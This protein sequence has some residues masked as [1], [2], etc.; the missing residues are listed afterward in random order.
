LSLQYT[1]DGPAPNYVVGGYPYTLKLCTQDEVE[2]VSF[3]YPADDVPLPGRPCLS[4][5]P[6]VYPNGFSIKDLRGDLEFNVS[7]RDN[8]RYAQ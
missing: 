6:F 3:G 2:V 8:G 4:Q 5:A 1:G 7:A